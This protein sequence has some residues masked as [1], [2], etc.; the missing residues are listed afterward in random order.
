MLELTRILNHLLNI[1]CHAGDLG[2]LLC[3]LWLFEDREL[4][5]M[6][7]SSATGARLHSYCFIPGGLR[8]SLTSALNHDLVVYLQGLVGRL[9]LIMVISVQHRLWLHRLLNVGIICNGLS[10]AL[11]GVLLRSNGY[12]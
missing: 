9:E 7:S 8:T 10:G 5:Y 12:G 4:L 2:C 3:V 11:T 6:L 1:A